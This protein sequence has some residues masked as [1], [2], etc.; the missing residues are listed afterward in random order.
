MNWHA[1]RAQW[2]RN[3]VSVPAPDDVK[4]RFFPSYSVTLS[5]MRLVS[6]PSPLPVV[7]NLAKKTETP[8]IVGLF[9]PVSPD[10]AMRYLW[11]S[12][13]RLCRSRHYTGAPIP[14]SLWSPAYG[15]YLAMG[16]QFSPS[17]EL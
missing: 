3:R 12:F 1:K 4:M 17:R 14:P 2:A 7:P 9:C 8:P 15:T 5:C 11:V 16:I 13:G 10:R 6:L